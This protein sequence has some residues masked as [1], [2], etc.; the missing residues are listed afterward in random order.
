[1]N[2]ERLQACADVLDEMVVQFGSMPEQKEKVLEAALFCSMAQ[3]YVVQYAA[4]LADGMEPY[5][6]MAVTVKGERKA[7][8]TKTIVLRVLGAKPTE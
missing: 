4:H 5:D 7:D 6:A 2:I 3:N 1:M 8:E